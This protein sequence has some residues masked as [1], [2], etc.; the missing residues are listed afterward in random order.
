MST[1]V[2]TALYDIKRTDGRSLDEYKK[3]FQNLL[4]LNV[5]MVIFIP[6]YLHDFVKEHRPKEYKTSIIQREFEEL[7]TYKYLPRIKE[8]IQSMKEKYHQY[9]GAFR[10]KLEY[11]CPEYGVVIY[12]KLFLMNEVIKSNPY[13]SEY[14]VW[15]D[16]GTYRNILPFD[17]S[18]PWPDSSKM[19]RFEDKYFIADDNID[20]EKGDPTSPSYIV[21]PHSAV[22]A[23]IMGGNKAA[24]KRTYHQFKEKIEHCFDNLV[25]NNEQRV[26]QALIRTYPSDYYAYPNLRSKYRYIPEITRDRMIAYELRQENRFSEQYKKDDCLK[27]VTMISNSVPEKDFQKWLT[28]ADYFGYDYEIIGRNEPWK[29]W[30]GRIRGY[31]KTCEESKHD[32]LCFT[33]STDVFFTGPPRELYK[34]FKSMKVNLLIGGESR[35]AYVGG[36]S[37]NQITEILRKEY[38]NKDQIFPNGGL[39]IGYK[40]NLIELFNTVIDYKDDQTGYIDVKYKN[41]LPL[42]VDVNTKCFANVPNYGSA[43]V[44]T[45]AHMQYDEKETR[46]CNIIS[47]EYP[48][49]MHF[50][51][52]NDEINK[53]YGRLFMNDTFSWNDTSN[54]SIMPIIVLFFIL[55]IIALLIFWFINRK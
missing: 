37:K 21:N 52:H 15:M 19:K 38:P 31:L 30:N 42:E 46:Y 35:I 54:G 55:L 27:L 34:K 49:V 12:G 48:S 22:N 24:I 41:I 16:A 17:F 18:V 25:Y 7:A 6:S 20:Q 43:R 29:G 9:S 23:H 13:N 10:Q 39:L 5:P 36:E 44:H 26:I 28:T 47:G 33:D 50:P 1:T 14:F 32:I 11:N 51:G 4:K 40:K 45:S 3:W 2:I 53:F 8:S